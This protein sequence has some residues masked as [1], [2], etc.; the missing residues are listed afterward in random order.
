MEA[1]IFG[2]MIAMEE[3]IKIGSG[4]SKKKYESISNL[5]SFTFF[6]FA[7]IETII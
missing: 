2:S 7:D 3:K 5:Y 1:L 6:L 4:I